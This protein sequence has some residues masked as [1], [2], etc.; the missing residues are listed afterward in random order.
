VNSLAEYVDDGHYERVKEF[1]KLHGKK[2]DP[3][4][5]GYS[6]EPFLTDV[7]AGKNS[8]FYNAHSYHTK[9]PPQGIEPFIEHYTGAGD[10][11]LDPFCGSGM[12]GVAAVKLGRIPLLLD[13]SPI[14][15][16]IAYNNCTPL[17]NRKFQNEA[18][19]I[20]NSLKDELSWLYDTRC[21][22]CGRVSLIEQLI[23]SDEFRCPRCGK[24]FLLWDVAITRDGLVSTHFD[25]PKCGKQLRKNDCKRI[26]SKPVIVDY[27]CPKCGRRQS[28]PSDFDFEK[29]KEIDFRWEKSEIAISLGKSDGFW[30]LN[31]KNER[32]WVPTSK[33]PEG[34][35][36]REPVSHNITHVHQFYT[37]RTLWAL[38][39]IWEAIG[40]AKEERIREG[41]RWVFTS[42][43]PSLVSRLTRY[44]FGKRG[45]GP[46]T[47]TLYIPSFTV[48]RNVESIWMNKVSS[49]S[50]VFESMS[51]KQISIVSTQSAT[52]VSNIPSDIIDYVF[53][54]P[55]FGGNLMYS[56]LNFIWESWL[57]RFTDS[58][59]EAIVNKKQSKGITEY[60]NLMTQ[61]FK[62]VYRVLKPGRWMTMVFHNSDG[63]VWQAIQEG[64]ANA[65][66]VIGMIGIF[67]K[68][69]RSFNQVSSSGAVG[70]DVVMNCY[71]PK[72]TVKNG[73]EGKTT[74]IGIVG[75]IADQLLKMPLESGE[76]RTARKL[77]SKAI[78]FF[79]LQNKPLRNLS[80]EDF[81]NILKKNF[82][83]IDEHWYLPYQRPKTG[84]QKR[85]FGYVSNETEALG[86]LE[87]VLRIPRKC[88]DILPDFF[89]A[90]GPNK[91]QK[92]L[93]SMLQ[94]N[95]VEEKGEWRNPTNAEKEHLTKKL[96]DMT[97]RQITGYLENTS[98]YQPKDDELC[99]WIEFCYNSGLFQEGTELFCRLNENMVIAEVFKKAKKIAEICKLKMFEG[100][101]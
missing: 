16:F 51:T 26:A 4:T 10:L 21:E 94:E 25:C 45:S 32:L 39:R 23:W 100:S 75:F 96:T 95:F 86:W 37:S 60:K 82:R 2:Y 47:G 49:I 33:L 70:Y 83:E 40:N 6:K 29:L 73:I 71:K 84:S 77:H 61:S 62:E 35:K 28:P 44:N 48:E 15:T 12:T 13:L 54:D 27:K 43:N 38:G 57:G 42:F 98:E 30:P 92:D 34:C 66:F 99:E 1:I 14:A 24:E 19:D 64:L 76:N 7:K 87:D 69:Q 90:M 80:F 78:G 3:S 85:L 53:T 68:K 91:L 97:A 11:V 67:D 65:G 58:S 46:L 5:D 72:A 41:L 63:E 17:D 36:T 89:K 22:K 101:H 88:G 18:E 20:L 81:Q 9:V 74:N 50:R 55:P 93:Q 31:Q 56:E 79:M 8:P 59:E 52:S